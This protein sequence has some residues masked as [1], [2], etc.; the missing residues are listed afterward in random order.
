MKNDSRK[1]TVSLMLKRK[2][3]SNDRQIMIGR[4]L[5]L[6]TAHGLVHK[7]VA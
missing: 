4:R 1:R 5:K 6:N 3:E 7:C 2:I